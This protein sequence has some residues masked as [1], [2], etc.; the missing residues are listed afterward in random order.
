MTTEPASPAGQDDPPAGELFPVEP[1]PGGTGWSYS[2]YQRIGRAKITNRRLGGYE[3]YGVRQRSACSASG[4]V[5]S[6]LVIVIM[7]PPGLRW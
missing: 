7:E 2:V 5:C 3:L 6:G 4:V 1:R